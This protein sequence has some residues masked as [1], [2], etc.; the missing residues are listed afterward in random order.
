MVATDE[1]ALICDFAETYHILE[2]RELKPSKAAIL[3][4]GLDGNSRIKRKLSNSQASIET[5]LLAAITDRLSFLV[6]AKTKDGEKGKNKPES[7]VDLITGKKKNETT[8][9]ATSYDYEKAR[10]EIL[11]S[12]NA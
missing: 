10:Q 4:V 1:D 7:L 2:W 8:G 3:A 9:F 5:L 6:W 11:R 12:Q